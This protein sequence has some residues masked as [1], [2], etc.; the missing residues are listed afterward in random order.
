MT[1]YAAF[2]R[3]V[4]LGPNRRISSADLRSLSFRAIEKLLGATTVRTK[5]TIDQLAAKYFSG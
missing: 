2:L 4:N 3:A 1:Q 5:G